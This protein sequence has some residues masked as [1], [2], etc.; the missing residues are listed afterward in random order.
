[1]DKK[2]FKPIIPSQ[3]KI[4]ILG[5]LPGDLSIAINQYYG[6]PR[7]RFWKILFD[8]YNKEHQMEYEERINFAITNQIAIW[9]VAYSAFRPGSM[10]VDI[11]DVVPNAIDELI[12]NYPTIKKVIFN[13]KKA[14]QMFNQFFERKEDIEYYV[15][16]STSP[17]N[18][19]YSYDK[20]YSIWEE[21]I[22]K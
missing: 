22:L 2:S 4:L 7:N 17:A 21:A 14:E 9:D 20:L 19:S 1:M 11:K 12:I 13:G 5:S 15:L 3:P 6:H 18:A 8:L 16:P 10:D